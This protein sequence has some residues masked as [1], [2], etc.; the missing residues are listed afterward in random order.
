M[1]RRIGVP[2]YYYRQQVAQRATARGRDAAVTPMPRGGGR[3]GRLQ[4]ASRLSGHPAL[5]STTGVA[6]TTST[7]IAARDA[8]AG[9]ASP[10]TPPAADGLSP[11]W[12]AGAMAV[13]TLAFVATRAVMRH[14]ADRKRERP[15]VAEEVRLGWRS[16]PT[17]TPAAFVDCSGRVAPPRTVE[18]LRAEALRLIP[19]CTAELV[20]EERTADG[21]AA[22]AQY[23]ALTV[24]T[25]FEPTRLPGLVAQLF[26]FGYADGRGTL[27]VSEFRL[28]V[29]DSL[30]SVDA[31]TALTQALQKTLKFSGLPGVDS[32]VHGFA[33][34]GGTVHAVESL[35]ISSLTCFA[36]RL[37]PRMPLGTPEAHLQTILAGVRQAS[38]YP[39]GFLQDLEL[40]YDLPSGMSRAEVLAFVRMLCRT[41]E[42]ADVSSYAVFCDE[43]F[44]LALWTVGMVTVG[45][46]VDILRAALT[47]EHFS[48]NGSVGWGAGLGSV[49]GLAAGW[50]HGRV[51]ERRAAVRE[52]TASE[53]SGRLHLF[54]DGAPVVSL[55]RQV[56]ARGWAA[57]TVEWA[58][59]ESEAA[60]PMPPPVTAAA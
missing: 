22:V 24:P 49:L 53:F 31:W 15:L 45:T 35:L 28:L 7:L 13:G 8:Y 25:G 6:I 43:A 44:F 55:H 46:E 32:A 27:P 30:P 26:Q 3:S 16:H 56:Y 33:R 42:F 58:T 41:E 47:A 5:A 36:V 14:R 60:R 59:P 21:V 40:R 1:D 57:T 20:S 18:E 23:F 38:D 17:L 2:S 37:R 29:S 52:R 12:V 50:A 48:W 11:Q 34:F 4:R 19:G 9:V 10:A 54:V 51:I 39:W